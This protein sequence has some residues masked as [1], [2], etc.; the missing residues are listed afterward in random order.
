L[1]GEPSWDMLLHL[2]AGCLDGSPVSIAQCCDTSGA[3]RSTALRWLA[4]LGN[5]GL[6]YISE[7]HS[8]GSEPTIAITRLGFDKISSVIAG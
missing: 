5:S 1:F 8:D 3:P 6:C 2:F 7:M 4:I